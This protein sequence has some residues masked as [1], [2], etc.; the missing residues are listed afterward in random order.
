[1]LLRRAVFSR[2]VLYL[3][4][5]EA[6]RDEQIAVRDNETEANFNF[7]LISRR[8]RLALLDRKSG[9]VIAEFGND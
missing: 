4:L 7:Q 5:S 3:F 8:A 6:A 1:V 9:R 2:A